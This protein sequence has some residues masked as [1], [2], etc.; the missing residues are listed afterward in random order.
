MLLIPIL[1]AITVI[2]AIEGVKADIFEKKD[3]NNPIEVSDS[4]PASRGEIIKTSA[5]KTTFLDGS[6]V[7]KYSHS[8]TSGIHIYLAPNDAKFIFYRLLVLLPI[9]NSNKKAF[10]IITLI[11]V[12]MLQTA[13]WLKQSSDGSLDVSIPLSYIFTCL[14]VGYV[15]INVVNNKQRI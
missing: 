12:L 9:A 4:L 13:Y 8:A 11:V 2:I 14:I 1:M 5:E 15:C 3:W 7:E 6:Y 10:A